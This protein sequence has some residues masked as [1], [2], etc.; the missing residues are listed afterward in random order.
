MDLMADGWASCQWHI[1][2]LVGACCCSLLHHAFR[3]AATKIFHDAGL[4]MSF[5]LKLNH[6]LITYLRTCASDLQGYILVVF[7]T[8]LSLL[9]FCYMLLLLALF[10][11]PPSCH[12]YLNIISARQ[13]QRHQHAYLKVIGLPLEWVLPVLLALLCA[14]DMCGQ[15]VLVVMN[16]VE[17]RPVL[18]Q[19]WSEWFRDVLGVDDAATG[20]RLTLTLMRPAAL[21]AAL[22]MSRCV[23]NSWHRCNAGLRMNNAALGCLDSQQPGQSRQP[24]TF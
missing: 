16:V 22:C 6:K 12:A 10:L 19:E 15:Y 9:G 24:S 23:A 17:D 2:L 14:L 20:R 5:A 18:P 3:S 4:T 13:Q 11:L 1:L 8:P 21:L 7:D